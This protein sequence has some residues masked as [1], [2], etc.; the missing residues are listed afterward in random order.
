[1]GSAAPDSMLRAG[2]LLSLILQAGGVRMKASGSCWVTLARNPTEV[3]SEEVKRRFGTAV[4]GES[5]AR[6]VA[7]QARER[8][9]SDHDATLQFERPGGKVFIRL[10]YVKPAPDAAAPASVTATLG[11][12][13]SAICR[14]TISC[15]T[16][17][18]R[19]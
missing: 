5:L 17:T 19:D 18:R 2:A 11:P 3:T 16:T 9:L 10:T 6:R 8:G 1:M 14:G 4:S 12:T 15:E 7:R 13:P